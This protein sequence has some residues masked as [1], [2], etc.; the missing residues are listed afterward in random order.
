[1]LEDDIEYA[2]KLFGYDK[3]KDITVEDENGVRHRTLY[4]YF[5][6]EDRKNYLIG[7]I[8]ESVEPLG[9][10]YV[11]V[12]YYEDRLEE[13]KNKSYFTWIGSCPYWKALEFKFENR[14]PTFVEVR[15]PPPSR[16]NLKELLK[17]VNLPIYDRFEYLRRRQG[18]GIVDRLWV[19]DKPDDFDNKTLWWFDPLVEQI[20]FP[21][22]E[23][24]N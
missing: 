23:D 15:T 5:T 12:K 7:E 16:P 8:T 21:P 14:Y 24:N 19:S 1:M 3:W 20:V 11:T 18:A 22:L 6:N 2:R 9:D 17:E 10:F 4:I 13:N